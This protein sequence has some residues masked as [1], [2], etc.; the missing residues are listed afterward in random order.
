MLIVHSSLGSPGATTTSLHL[1]AQWA[2]TGTEVLLI[3]A[4]PGGGSIGHHLGIHFTPG[5]A[6]FIASGQPVSGGNLIDHSQDVLLSNLHV[7]PATSSP[8]G[9]REIARWFDERAEALREVSASEVAI[10]VDAGRISGGVSGANL[11]SQA[12]GVVVVARG[13][14]A[15]ASLD[16][17]GNLLSAEVRG[18]VE[19]CVVTIGDSP[20]SAEAWQEKFA[21]RFCGS[22]SQYAEVKGDLSAYLNRKKRKAKPWRLSLEGVAGTLLPYTNAPAT[23]GGASQRLERAT[24]AEAIP[25]AAPVVSGTAGVPTEPENGATQQPVPAA[26]A[27]VAAQQPVPAAPAPVAAAP[28]VPEA[29]HAVPLEDW[30]G[31]VASHAQLPPPFNTSD[32]GYWEPS[33]GWEPTSVEPPQPVADDAFGD[34]SPLATSTPPPPAFQQPQ[35]LPPEPPRQVPPH[36]PHEPEMIAPQ[37]PAAEPQA[38]HHPPPPPQPPVHQGLQEPLAPPPPQP[39]VH[40]GM[41]EPLAPAPP[42]PPVH[43]GMQEPSAPAPPRPPVHEG[44]QEPSAPAP[45]PLGAEPPD[46]GTEPQPEVSASGSFR[47]WASRLYGPAPHGNAGAEA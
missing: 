46:S 41:Q 28:Q 11:R 13:D 17:I 27:P 1:A 18:D 43:Q 3:E 31:G 37:G 33:P 5:S 32:A 7:M 36:R 23:G 4:D 26:P 44:M 21:V 16:R 6:S 39:P 40:E 29:V 47:D 35:A 38:A 22:I 8:S 30:R 12:T 34:E 45:P 19:R 25:E 42:Q 24:E 15:P 20:M 10:I 14:G 9:A 2:A